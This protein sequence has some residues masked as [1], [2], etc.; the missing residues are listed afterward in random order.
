MTTMTDTDLDLTHRIGLRL[1]AARHARR[2]S[3]S[4]LSVLTGGRYSKSRISNY[5]QGLRRLSVEGAQSLAKV[6]GNVSAA[7]LL[8]L[9]DETNTTLSNAEMQLID[10]YRRADAAS[11]RCVLVCARAAQM[12][13]ESGYNGDGGMADHSDSRP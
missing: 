10:A 2:L 7:H 1:R 5:E 6:L 13:L 9:D 8:C 4:T 11:R 12:D 3:L